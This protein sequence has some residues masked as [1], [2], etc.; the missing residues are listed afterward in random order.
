MDSLR[1]HEVEL[2]AKKDELDVVRTELD[3]FEVRFFIADFFTR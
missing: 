2:S 3:M 1:N